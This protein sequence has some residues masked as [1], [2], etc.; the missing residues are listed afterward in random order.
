M[1]KIQNKLN[2]AEDQ[3]TTDKT[4]K[5]VKGF[6]SEL[7]GVEPEQI[8]LSDRLKEELNMGP[9]ELT[10]LS[11]KL[12]DEQIKIDLTEIKTVADLLDAV[13]EELELV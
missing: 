5:K 6:I 11:Q 8:E 12:A 1:N 13:K 7:I 10:E 2:T 9:T 3:N 4:S